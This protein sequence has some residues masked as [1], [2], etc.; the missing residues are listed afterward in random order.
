MTFAW[1]TIYI[2]QITSIF[3]WYDNKFYRPWYE[4]TNTKYPQNISIPACKPCTMCL[5]MAI[6]PGLIF[7]IL[8][9]TVCQKYQIPIVDDNLSF[10]TFVFASCSLSKKWMDLFSR[11]VQCL[12]SRTDNWK[13][14]I[15]W[16]VTTFL[17][18]SY[19]WID[20]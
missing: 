1:R 5:R 14:S 2:H 19:S 9:Y 10:E 12:E 8:R 13:S 20:Q 16:K 11:L 17:L 18:P 6:S 3:H 4:D 15:I 7:R